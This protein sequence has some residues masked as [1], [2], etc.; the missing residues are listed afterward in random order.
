[1]TCTHTTTAFIV[2]KNVRR[3][4]AHM[5]TTTVVVPDP[6]PSVSSA[7]VT[8]GGGG[9]DRVVAI[10][11]MLKQ[12]LDGA[13]ADQKDTQNAVRKVQQNLGVRRQRIASEEG[14]VAALHRS[15]YAMTHD[16]QLRQNA[17]MLTANSARLTRDAQ[18]SSYLRQQI[19]RTDYAS[20]RS[21]IFD[22]PV[23]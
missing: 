15:L 18:L 1:M 4:N 22:D 9:E 21:R 13:L 6:D 14:Q 5:S 3:I 10:Q 7:S 23:V 11:Q 12:K 20:Y 2:K 16:P 17:A 19:E 8:M